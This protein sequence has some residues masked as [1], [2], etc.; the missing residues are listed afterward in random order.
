MIIIRHMV[1]I[2]L[3]SF[4][5]SVSPVSAK[6]RTSLPN[7]ITSLQN[8][9]SNTYRTNEAKEQLAAQ[10]DYRAI[11]KLG[12]QFQD[13]S[14]KKGSKTGG[15][16]G[17]P[18]QQ[19]EGY[20]APYQTQKTEPSESDYPSYLGAGQPG[21]SPRQGRLNWESLR[22]GPNQQ[23]ERIQGGDVPIEIPSFEDV[24]L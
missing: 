14:Q 3:S 20:L 8:W 11:E 13:E 4:F 10:V 22:G 23:G 12:K 21:D 5:I 18:S 24:N 16:G 19:T 7:E 1:I 17:S 6:P 9:I 15:L 2:L